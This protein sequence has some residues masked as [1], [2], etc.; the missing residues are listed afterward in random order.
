MQ[1]EFY[2]VTELSKLFDVSRAAIH[3]WVDDGRF[4][5]LTRVGGQGMLLIPAS[6]VV[7]VV[8]EERRKLEEQLARYDFPIAIPA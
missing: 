5:N 7:A 6:D 8:K 3:N 2:T 4:P 1:Q